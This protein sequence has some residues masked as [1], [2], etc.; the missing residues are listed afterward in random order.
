MYGINTK[1]KIYSN[2]NPNQS[3]NN[4]DED[5]PLPTDGSYH[6]PIVIAEV[7]FN[8]WASPKSYH[9]NILLYLIIGCDVFKSCNSQ[10]EPRISTDND[11]LTV[12]F[13]TLSY[14]TNDLVTLIQTSW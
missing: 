4:M 10:V 11:Y 9:T 8:T 14:N 2:A 1:H 13:G 12:A 3:V 6:T 7:M 5:I